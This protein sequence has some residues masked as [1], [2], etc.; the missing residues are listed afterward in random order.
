[1]GKEGRKGCGDG[2]FVAWVLGLA[3]SWSRMVSLDGTTRFMIHAI[4]TSETPRLSGRPRDM[5]E[6]HASFRNDIDAQT[7]LGPSTIQ[8]CPFLLRHA[9]NPTPTPKTIHEMP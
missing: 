1:M 9:P 5:I 8:K 6:Q 4:T 2:G 3:W 7:D